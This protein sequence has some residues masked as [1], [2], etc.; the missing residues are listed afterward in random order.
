M[1]AF[2]ITPK[3]QVTIPAQIREELKLKPGDRIFYEKTAAGI[4]LKP[5]KRSMMNDYGFLK[6]KAKPEE[7]L[8]SIR[9]AIR[10]KMAARSLL[11]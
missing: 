8:E 3:G 1:K 5:A 10:K 2:T 9:K 6:G 7:D 4:L 11:K